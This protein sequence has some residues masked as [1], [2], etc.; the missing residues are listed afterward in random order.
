LQGGSRKKAREIIKDIDEF[1]ELG[2]FFDQPVET[3]STGMRARL[4]FATAV[5]TEVDILFIDE[6]L[7][8]GDV[9][10]LQK[11]ESVMVD[12][13]KGDQTCVFVSHSPAQVN[14]ICSKVIWIED[15]IIK[16]EGDPEEIT[17]EYVEYMRV[18]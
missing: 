14:K 12:K 5:M 9:Y 10:F 4:G 17:Q 2:E 16:R 3:Y 13:L 7:S 11:A 15:G 18:H 6:V 8:V 1:A